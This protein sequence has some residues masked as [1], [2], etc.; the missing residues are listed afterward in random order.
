M[1]SKQRLTTFKKL[2]DKGELGIVLGRLMLAMNDIGI[3][4]DALGSWMKEQEGIRRD[5]QKGAKMY[6]VRMLISHVF[7][8]LTVINKIR[9][10]PELM[11]IVDRSPA[12][13]KAA[14][15]RSAAV[16]GTEKY[17]HMKE[18][19]SGLGF[20]YL[21]HPVRGAIESQGKKVPDLQLSLSVGHDPLEWYYEPGDRIVDS[22]VV[23]E[24]FKIPEG[25][26]VQKEVDKLIHDIQSVGDDLA[27][28]A[29]YFIMENAT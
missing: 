29:G 10:M 20:H 26:D 18:L 11:A 28:F 5:R 9:N 25:D 22:A 13:T 16:I 24:I 4:N 2:N 6:F 8:A 15:S 3:A 14:F 27:A 17:K 23:R 1:S 19:R 21:D 12:P 7:E